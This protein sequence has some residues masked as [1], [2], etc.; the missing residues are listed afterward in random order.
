MANKSKI[1]FGGEVLMDLTAD[2]I[3]A[4][5]LLKGYTAHSADGEPI[6]GNLLP[7]GK[8]EYYVEVTL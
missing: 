4:D 6:T 8:K 3:K 1:V 7:K 5:K 2:T